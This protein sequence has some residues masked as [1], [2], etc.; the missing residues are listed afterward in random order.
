[1]N[2]ETPKFSIRE[3][4]KRARITVRTLRFYEELGLLVPTERNE[5]GHRLYGLNE[6]AKLQQIQSMKFLGYPLQEIKEF[7]KDEIE[8]A[9]QLEKSLPWQHKLLTE[10]RDELN[11]SIEAVERVQNLLKEGIAVNWT[12][13][14]SLLFQIEHEEDLKEWAK[15]YLPEKVAEKYFSLPKEYQQKLDVEMLDWLA[16]LEKLMQDSVPANSPEAFELLMELTELAT[17]HVEDKEAFAIEL[18]KAQELMDQEIMDFQ[19]PTML[20]PEQE[21]YLMKIGEE[22]EALYKDSEE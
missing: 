15:E 19:F 3:F 10:K 12:V 7:I 8:V 1:M 14:S 17:R 21:S 22:M 4:S 9:A 2:Q 5:S 6:L 11:R 13:L 20:T 16:K 18:E